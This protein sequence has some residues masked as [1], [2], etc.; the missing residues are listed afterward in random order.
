MKIERKLLPVLI[1]EFRESNKIIIIYGARQTGKTTLSNDILDNVRGN[2]LKV[3]G[4]EL[5]YIDVL[6]SRDLTKM[7]LL[8][9][10]H[11]ILFIDEAQRIPDIGINLKIIHDNIPDVK[12]LVTGSSSLDLANKVKEPLTGRTSTYTL[13]PISLSELSKTNSVIELQSRLEE[14]M[15]YGLYPELFNLESINKKEKYLRELAGSYLYKDIFDIS[16]IRNT[17]KIRDLLKLLALQI[18]S[19]VSLNELG[20]NLGLNLETVN[21]YINLLEK[22]FIVFRL[23]GFNRNLRKEISKRDKIFFWDMGIRNSIIDNFSSVSL[24][25]DTGAMWENFIISERL[26]YLSYNEIYASSYFWRTYTGAELDYIEEI[27]GELSGY[28]IKYKKP[29]L[30]PPKTWVDNYSNNYKCITT[31]NFWE[32][33]I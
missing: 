9:N 24:R 4:D 29:K 12:L 15:V 28:E 2:V 32:F 11:D 21:A 25:T 8:I 13:Y 33:V 30:K 18:G 10:G 14:F 22:S 16:R 1:N 31:D 20:N 7:K 26:K 6:S 19:E 5:R 17:S 27:N 3:N 23:S